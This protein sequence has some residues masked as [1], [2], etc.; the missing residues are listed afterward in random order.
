MDP[1]QMIA[2]SEAIWSGSIVFSKGINT[3]SAGQELSN[4]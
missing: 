2:L 4:L 3:G 1:D